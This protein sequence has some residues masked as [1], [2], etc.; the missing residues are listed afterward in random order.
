MNNL[1]WDKLKIINENIKIKDEIKIL[2]EKNK[3]MIIGDKPLQPQLY[4][5]KLIC[6]QFFRNR[7]DLKLHIEKSHNS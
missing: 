3:N 2:N 6:D 1:K 5:E 4:C 7:H